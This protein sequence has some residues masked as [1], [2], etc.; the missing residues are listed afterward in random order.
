MTSDPRPIAPFVIGI[1]TG[2]TFTDL[3]VIDSTG[4]I[5][6]EKAFSTP[7]HPDR[8]IIDVLIKFA[9]HWSL[10]LSGLLKKTSRFAHG[11][12]VGTNALIQRKG[13]RVG[14]LTTR[15][16]ED[17]LIIARGPIGRAGG[18]PQS[19]A[20][21]FIHTEPP[22]PLVPKN[23]IRGIRERVTVTAEE[24]LPL[25]EDGA[26][27]AVGELLAQ[28]VDCIAVCL[29]W[30]FR[31]PTHERRIRNIIHEVALELPVYLSSEIAPRMGE[32][33]RMVTTV[34]N[35][36]VGPRIGTYVAALQDRLTTE[37]LERPLQIMTA[38]GGVTL[39]N[40]VPDKAVSIINS[41]PVGGLVASRALGDELGYRNVITADMGGTS[42]DVGLIA[43]GVFEEEQ[44]PYLDQGLPVFSPALKIVT[45]G[46]GG[47]SIAVSDGDRLQVGPESAGSDPGPACYGR[48]NDRPTVTDAL[49][50][51][52]IVNPENFFGGHYQL[53]P[54]LSERAIETHIATPL[55][56]SVLDAAGGIYDVV[57]ARM[58]DLIRKVT[59]ES[60]NDPRDCCLMAYGG[61][62]GAHCALF[63]RQLGI[64]RI[65]LPLA[66]PVFS[67]LGIAMSDI[68]YV[69]SLSAP[70]TLSD[71]ASVSQIVSNA[72]SELT[73]QV[74]N[75]MQSSGIDAA[76]VQFHY[77]IEMRYQGQMNE[78]AVPWP[79]AEFG[80]ADME[81]LRQL[82]EA[83]YEK[84]FGAGT[85]RPRTPLELISYRVEGVRRTALPAF[86]PTVQ[87][88]TATTR[89]QNRRIYQRDLG[90]I[91]SQVL[92]LPALSPGEIMTGPAIIEASATTV[93]LPA[94]A[95]AETDS[96][97]N[98]LI[99]PGEQP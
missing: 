6:M 27:Q 29:L 45:I 21:D 2:G 56:L 19:R 49:V 89:P 20:M 88:G 71:A 78:V 74:T 62:S 63:A 99:T 97:G 96:L 18:I 36:F 92:S 60:G 40:R 17:T 83:Q 31:D 5:F 24:I 14:L 91:D 84:R 70:V 39:A 28:D 72:F 8:A 82:F 76:D 38:S 51:L 68:L 10:S 48:G 44:I 35:G 58:A 85:T 26:R 3:S 66:A 23:L 9:E 75:D 98:L 32:F 73:G 55:G 79:S 25:D 52:G 64:P 11:T 4:R 86:T 69:H 37:G 1:D 46:A 53:D 67:A 81:R 95:A 34:I 61:G 77:R 47:G 57:T 30:S 87:A 43:D 90:W 33:E 59:V 13:A 41:G 50:T 54:A 12:T 65:V 7:D 42:F 80:D 22:E 94:G 16:F 93:W 15:G